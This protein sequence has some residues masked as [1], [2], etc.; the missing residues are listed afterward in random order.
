MAKKQAKTY[1][2]LTRGVEQV[3]PEEVAEGK[4]RSG[5]KLRVYLGID[6]TGSK[7]HIGHSVPLRKLQAF[8][9][10]GHEAIF[11]IGS[12][13]AMIG[14]PTGRDAA[15]QPLTREQVEANFQTYKKQAG[16]ILDFSKVTIRYNHEWLEKLSSA[17][18]FKIMSHFTIQQ[19]LQRDMFKERMKHDEDLS[20]MEF[21]Y[22]L[23]Q[24][25]D[26]VV[27]DV[28]AEIGGNDQLFNMLCG[29]KLQ[30][31]YGKREKF[32]IATK[33]LEGLD[34]R[35]MSKTYGNAVNITDEPNDM[36][37]KIMSLRD[38][39]IIRYFELCTDVPLA[40]IEGIK[41]SLKAGG[42]PRDAKA[43]LAREIVEMYHGA[44]A[45]QAA[46]KEFNAVFRSGALPA[47]IPKKK[48]SGKQKQAD[49]LLVALGLAQSR[50]EAKRLIEQGGV[51]MNG[52]VLSD[53]KERVDIKKGAVVQV[54]K[55][56]FVEIS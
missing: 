39:L 24:A 30:E 54:G 26:S 46:E 41:K 27:L 25:Y 51:R 55:R 10:A 42:N 20:P 48:V 33:L 56:R 12:F 47:D 32:V 1:E 31:R 44:K 35:K 17:E 29:R 45:A 38:D 4:L 23:M 52:A 5:K 19:M 40:E 6:P 9:D 2:L 16:R 43:R 14:D 28:D 18:T 11:L 21:M 50:S 13:T 49:E 7:L 8:A 53:W 22:P 3:V 36:F 15:R 34:G 37:G